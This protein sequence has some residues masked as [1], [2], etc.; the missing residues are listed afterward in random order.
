MFC[1]HL[2]VLM[3]VNARRATIGGKFDYPQLMKKSE[4]L[5]CAARTVPYIIPI[6]YKPLWFLHFIIFGHYS[7]LGQ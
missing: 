5:L 7:V 2:A 6:P 4:S 3:L 1:A